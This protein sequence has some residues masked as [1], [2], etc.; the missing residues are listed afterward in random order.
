[1][2]DGYMSRRRD[3]YKRAHGISFLNNEKT[4]FK[5]AARPSNHLLLLNHYIGFRLAVRVVAKREVLYS[6]ELTH[7]KLDRGNTVLLSQV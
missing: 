1:M 5:L 6:N 2:S 3:I 4:T 7:V